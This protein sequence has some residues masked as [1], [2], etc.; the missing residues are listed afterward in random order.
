VQDCPFTFC[1]QV[2]TV[3]P[4][5]IVQAWPGAQ[6]AVAVHDS[7]Q[8]PLAQAKLPHEKALGFW[9]VP[10]PSQVRAEVPEVGPTQAAAPHGVLA[11]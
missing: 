9:Q 5:G 6:S 7:L 11:G 1:P 3:W 2:P 8:A 10:S 4:L